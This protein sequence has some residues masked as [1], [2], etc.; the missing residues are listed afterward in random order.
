MGVTLGDA[1]GDGEA[2]LFLTHFSRDHNTLYRGLGEGSY[3][4]DSYR[5]GLGTPGWARM[6]WG[7]SFVDLDHDGDQDLYVANGHLYPCVM[8]HA[9]SAAIKNI[10]D[11]PFEEK[12]RQML[13]TW[14][15][16]QQVKQERLTRLAECQAC[17]HYPI[18]GAGCM[19]RAYT[20]SGDF[21]AVEDRCRLR[22]AV[23]AQRSV[24]P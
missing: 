14:R 22:K 3:E 7:T 15:R 9:N 1:D 24:D 6:G 11:R 23:Y 21:Y 16:L 19:G 13:G 18:C 20:A 2:D 4:D 12:F 8:L 5:S 17:D 10:Y